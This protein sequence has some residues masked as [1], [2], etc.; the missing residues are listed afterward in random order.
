MR[1]LKSPIPLF[2]LGLIRCRAPVNIGKAL[3][4]LV[5]A[6]ALQPSSSCWQACIGHAGSVRSAVLW[7]RRA[8]R[9]HACGIDRFSS[10]DRGR[11]SRTGTGRHNGDHHWQ[12]EDLASKRVREIGR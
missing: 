4:V 12:L 6:R 5:G 7:A 3:S 9:R 8:K 2:F 10:R 11:A 1:P